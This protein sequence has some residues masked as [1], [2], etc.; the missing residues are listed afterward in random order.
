[1]GWRRKWALTCG[2]RGKASAGEKR[3]SV[4]GGLER[5][6][7]QSG[8][9][10]AVLREHRHFHFE[11]EYVASVRAYIQV[12]PGDVEGRHLDRWVR[13]GEGKGAYIEGGVLQHFV[14]RDELGGVDID[15]MR[16]HRTPRLA[17]WL[18][19]LKVRNE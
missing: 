16:L 12:R 3:G 5:E 8:N 2:D 18:P 17:E 6:T 13:S 19:V 7:H 10:W 14:R 1:M 9:L 11:Q 4:S 15:K